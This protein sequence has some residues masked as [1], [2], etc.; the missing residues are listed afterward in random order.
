MP[1]HLLALLAI[2]TV[3]LFSGACDKGSAEEGGEGAESGGGAEAAESSVPS[4]LVG[5][6]DGT[7]GGTLTVN[8]NGRA[9]FA[10]SADLV[11]TADLT[12][13]GGSLGMDYDDGANSACVDG[14]LPY[15]LDGDT[16]TWGQVFNRANSDDDTSF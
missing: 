14:V 5:T 4:A 12:A 3:T 9:R 10:F 13:N 16:L 15:T 1:K 6:W 8:S 11:C 2:L 7:S